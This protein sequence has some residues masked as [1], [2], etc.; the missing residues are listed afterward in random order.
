MLRNNSTHKRPRLLITRERDAVLIVRQERKGQDRTGQDRTGQS[1]LLLKYP[2]WR[3]ACALLTKRF[4][5]SPANLAFSEA[6][7]SYL[8]ILQ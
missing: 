3:F 8:R 5:M 2:R 4:Q 1:N 6:E 7:F